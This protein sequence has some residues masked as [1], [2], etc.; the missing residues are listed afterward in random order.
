[1]CS[2]VLTPSIALI[3]CFLF[4]ILTPPHFSSR[5]QYPNRSAA[6]A[7][8]AKKAGSSSRASLEAARIHKGTLVSPCWP[9]GRSCFGQDVPAEAKDSSSSAARG[10][11]A[12]PAPASGAPPVPSAVSSSAAAAKTEP[13]APAAAAP[14]RYPLSAEQQAEMEQ[15]LAVNG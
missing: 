10:D 1:M 6:R 4:Y 11:Q 7:D 8:R 5:N 13:A 3:S 9:D 15:S 14:N 2:D 12:V